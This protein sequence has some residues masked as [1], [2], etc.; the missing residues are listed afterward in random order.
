MKSNFEYPDDLK[1][2]FEKARNMEKFTIVFLIC[3]GIIMFLT[4]GKSQAMKTA[5]VED[6]LSLMPPLAFL[7]ASSVYTKK[8]DSQFPYGYHRVITIAYLFSAVSLLVVGGYV[9][10]DALVKLVKAEHPT[11]GTVIIFGKPVWLGYMMILALIVTN[12]PIV[13]LGLRKLPLAMALREKNLYTDA[14][15]NKADWMTAI[16]AI[17]GVFGIGIGWWWAD[18]AAAAVISFDILHDGIKNVK[19]AVFDLMNQTPKTV[20]GTADEPL[21]KKMNEVL[22]GEEW[23]KAYTLR[24]RE[25]G[26]VFFAEAFVVPRTERNLVINIRKT[27]AKISLLSW[28]VYD[29][30]IVPVDHIETD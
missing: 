1:D 14:Q 13:V 18:A 21:I 27:S 25:E 16:A 12:I 17:F 24:T 6:V 4:M 11:I 10:V 19:Q 15:M 30:N 9:F 7:I 5:W 26:H 28:V 22:M 23:I 29:F 20:E 2:K 3:T 8:T